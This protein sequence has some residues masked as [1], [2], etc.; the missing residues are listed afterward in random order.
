MLFT[1]V[2]RRGK[3]KVGNMKEYEINRKDNWKNDV[4]GGNL[5]SK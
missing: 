2:I 5:C 1:G 3:R 4:K